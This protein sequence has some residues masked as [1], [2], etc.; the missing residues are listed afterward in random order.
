MAKSKAATTFPDNGTAVS[1][2]R[3]RLLTSLGAFPLAVAFQPVAQAFEQR[4]DVSFLRGPYQL[5]F[6]DA[7]AWLIA[8]VQGCIS[9]TASSMACSKG[10]PI[11]A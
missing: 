7:I 3:R 10:V 5:A 9:F 8:L 4:N 6:I 11:R 2:I 1:P